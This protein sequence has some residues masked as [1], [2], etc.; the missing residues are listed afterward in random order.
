MKNI[1]LLSLFASFCS[2]A[3]TDPTLDAVKKKMDAKDFIGA[4]SD[5][6]KII[7]TNPKNKNALTLRGRGAWRLLWS[8]R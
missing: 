4:K 6:T 1:L 2:Y 3:Q 7:E 8:D 5:L